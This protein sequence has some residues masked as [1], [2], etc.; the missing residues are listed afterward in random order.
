MR[1]QRTLLSA[2]NDTANAINCSLNDRAAF[3]SLLDD[4]HVC[5]S[6]EAERFLRCITISIRK[7]G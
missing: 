3:T 6:N 7:P 1:Q 2:K 5:L 4:G